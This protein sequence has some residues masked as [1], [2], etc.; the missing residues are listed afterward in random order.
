MHTWPPK[1]T[2]FATAWTGP[3]PTSTRRSPWSTWPPST[4][5]PPPWPT[6]PPASR[7]GWPASRSAAGTLLE[8]GA[9]P[10]RLA[11]RHGVHPARGD[12]AGPGRGQ[13]RRP[14]R[15]PDR[16]PGR[17]RRAGRRPGRSPR[18]ITLMV[19]ST[20]AARPHRRRARRP[21]S[22]PTLRVCL[23]LDASWRPLRGRVHVGVRRSPVHSARRGRRARRRRRRP[24][25]LPAGRR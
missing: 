2:S 16:R 11:R 13:R 24:A 21:G 14:G 25:R 19:D 7:S 1:A 10:A 9:G 4:P 23:D 6:A 3:P 22:A 5:T 8:P 12:L 18:P 17:A 15:V 20:G